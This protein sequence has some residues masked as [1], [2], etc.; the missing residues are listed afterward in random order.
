MNKKRL[1]SLTAGLVFALVSG[2]V[3]NAETFQTYKD[4]M[5]LSDAEAAKARPIIEKYLAQQDKLFAELKALPA[6]SPRPDAQGQD[7]NG[8]QGG[9]RGNGPADRTRRNG[10]RQALLQKFADNHQAA[11]AQLK[12]FLAP[13][14]IEAFQKTAAAGR[15]ATMRELMGNRGNRSN[16]PRNRP[17][18]N[19]S[20][21]AAGT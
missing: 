2:A 15:Q 5:K 13:D 7:N 9:N 11:V 6:P 4:A 17:N 16:G 1:A 21:G 20:A 14:Q 12:T 18:N 8:G 3:A 19:P 10:P